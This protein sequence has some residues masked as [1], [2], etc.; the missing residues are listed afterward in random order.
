MSNELCSDCT[1]IQTNTRAEFRHSVLSRHNNLVEDGVES[2]RY[3][4]QRGVNVYKYHC[5]ACGA[6]WE[7]EDD[8][9]DPN[10]GWS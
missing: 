5:S 6:H 8:S 7:Y 2:R 1:S 4:A 9:N 3:L 10:T